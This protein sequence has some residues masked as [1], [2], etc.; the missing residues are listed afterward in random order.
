MVRFLYFLT[1]LVAVLP[2]RMAF[3]LGRFGGWLCAHVFRVRRTYVLQTL[4]ACFP[5]KSE[6]ECRA[7][8]ARMCEQQLLNAVEILRFV[9][10]RDKEWR[11]AVTV[12]GME[13]AQRAQAKGKGVLIL[14]AH[15][16]NYPLLALNVPSV[17]GFPLS[18][19]AKTFKNKALN[20]IW[21]DL[22]RRAGVNGIASHNAY[23][24]CVRSLRRNEFIG[25]MLDQNRPTSQGVFVDFFGR[26]ASTSPGLAFMAAQTGAPIVPV[27]TRRLPD[28]RHVITILPEIEPPPDRREE[29]LLQATAHYTK[30]IEDQIR[31]HPEQWLWGHKR[32]KS[33]PPGEVPEAA[34]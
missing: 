18:I 21:W 4:A 29:T 10:G 11:D 23:R 13:I 3:G 30:V 14:I 32:W 15:F 28:G 26:L 5:D 2:K 24:A 27:F 16:G 22:Q 1:Q 7:I 25:F 17:F 20:D 12:E 33:R 34:V 19:V 9:G 31:N 6:K 8:Y